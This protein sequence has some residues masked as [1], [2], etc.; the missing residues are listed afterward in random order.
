LLKA[1]WEITIAAR[2]VEQVKELIKGLSSTF[3]IDL[4]RA[5]NHSS[6]EIGEWLAS[7]GKSLSGN[8][9]I[10]NATPVGMSPHP[11][12]SP[13]PEGLRLPEGAIVYDLVYN[14]VE[15][16]LIRL[17]RQRELEAANGL[18]MLVEQA[19]LAFERWTG[20]RP[21]RQAMYQAVSN[22]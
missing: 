1:G 8:I 9:L 7:S 17:A 20:M 11:N 14:P 10:V 3:E 19:A 4:L 18:G 12:A 5:I 13:W 15:T 6:P 21:D 2:R 22:V 16:L